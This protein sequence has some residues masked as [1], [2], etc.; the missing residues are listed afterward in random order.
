M[1]SLDESSDVPLGVEDVA[2]LQPVGSGTWIEA[3]DVQLMDWLNDVNG[4]QTGTTKNIDG[5]VLATLDGVRAVEFVHNY[6]LPEL[7]WDFM[8]DSR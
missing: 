2:A 7:L 4:F 6:E 3:A 5:F 8:P 1:A